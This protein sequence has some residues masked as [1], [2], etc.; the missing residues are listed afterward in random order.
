MKIKILLI[1]LI[2]L[3]QFKIIGQINPD[4]IQIVRDAYGVPHIFTKTDAELA[5]G[6]AWAHSEDDFET[7]QQGFLAGNA[8]MSDLIGKKGYGIDFITQFIGSERLFN[9]KYEKEISPEYK[10][11]MEAYSQGINRYAQLHPKKVLSKKLFPLTPKKMFLYA[12]LQLFVSSKGDFW[13]KKILGNKLTYKPVEDDVKGS[14]TFGFNSSKTKDGSTYLAINTHQPLDGPTSWYEVHLCSEQGTDIIGALF[15]GSPNILI[16]ANRNIAWAHT[17]NQPDKTDVYKLEMHPNKKRF[18][19]VDDQ[20]LQLKKHKAKIIVKVLG[21]PLKVSKKY[22]ESIYGPTLEN[23]SGFYSVRTPSLFEAKA[24]EQWWRMNKAESFSEF[25]S[26]LKMK[27]LPG[28]NIGYA[29]KNDTL[30]YISNGL[31]PKRVPGYDWAN[32]VPGN[33]K[34]TLWTSTY[35]IEELPQV[36]QP[37]SGYFYNAN[38][39]P[40]KSSD[41]LDN[42]NEAL[43]AK[44]MGFETYDN[45]R[46]KRIK[47]LIDEHKT[48]DYNDFKTIK[49]D[50]QLPKPFH[51]SWMNIDSLFMMTPENYPKVRSVLEQIQNWDRVAS[52][53]SYGAGAYGILYFKLAK[54]YKKLPQP[55]VFTKSILYKALIEAQEHMIEY[56]GQTQVKL[57]S[58]QKLVRGDKELPVFGLPDVITAMGSVPYKDG[59]TKVVKGESYIE[60]VKFTPQGV[61]I[62]SVISYG[63]SD[64]PE[65]KHY[66]DQMELYTSFKTKK[67]TFDRTSIFENASRIYHPK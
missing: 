50:H 24:L 42:P 13:V 14:N 32:V 17:V 18:Y 55:K 1:S 36:I 45:N 26:I 58:F 46:S 7:I 29:D 59:K 12:Q 43:F 22:F 66:S 37:S 63:S 39:S 38:H 62:E 52:A 54:Y 5:Y 47:Q 41:S 2:C 4:N 31:I 16:G 25:Y 56:F 40:F 49:Y 27:A 15:A 20:Y 19:R 61:D 57:G 48:V 21:I 11:I 3:I 65:S 30:F 34:K 10:L 53:D 64:D 23:D 67:M 51:Y 60:L 44:E 35:D 33:T 8:L 9:E 28:Y 6:L